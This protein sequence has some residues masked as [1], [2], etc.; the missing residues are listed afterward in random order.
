M[1]AVVIQWEPYRGN[2]PSVCLQQVKKELAN[3]ERKVSSSYQHR[4]VF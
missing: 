2:V 4:D 1:T 3:D